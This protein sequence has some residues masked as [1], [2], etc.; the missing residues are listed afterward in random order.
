MLLS[1]RSRILNFAEDSEGPQVIVAAAMECF[2]VMKEELTL[3]L[4]GHR[5]SF[6]HEFVPVFSCSK[7]SQGFAM[8][9]IVFFL[10]G[11]FPDRAS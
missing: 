3:S 1:L 4:I 8:F 11:A 2:K 9:C 7:Q 5:S 10:S 6:A